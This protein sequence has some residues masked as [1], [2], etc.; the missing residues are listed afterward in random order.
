MDKT[1]NRKPKVNFKNKDK[2]NWDDLTEMRESCSN[3]IV[4]Q[5]ALI[6][7]I[8]KV[9]NT[10]EKKSPETN[11]L[12]LGFVKSLEEC[13]IR[14]RYNSE[15][16]ITFEHMISTDL[17]LEDALN[18]PERFYQILDNKDLK[19]KEV[20]S[21]KKGSVKTSKKDITSEQYEYINA[22]SEYVNLGLVLRD[23]S[24]LP[25]YKIFAALGLTH[26]DVENF[27]K[28]SSII[29]EGGSDE[30]IM[31]KISN[32]VNKEEKEANGTNGK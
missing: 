6:G 7:E 20:K 21:I 31:E 4:S 11:A 27:S 3:M 1:T 23:L 32:E 15:K 12:I 2:F 5:F 10:L 19:A 26:K 16:H 28:I 22:N 30:E 8:N 9:Y 13:Y 29:Q 24:G 14:L 17:P 18:N 25:T